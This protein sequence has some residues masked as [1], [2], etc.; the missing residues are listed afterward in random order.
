MK[1]FYVVLCASLVCAMNVFAQATPA[2]DSK[3][4]DCGSSVT[5]TATPL[6]GYHFVQWEDDA[7]APAT[8]TISNIKD[9][10]LKNYKAIFAANQT[11]FG[12]GVDIDV[13]N[14]NVGDPITLTATPTDDCLE[15]T[16]WSDGNT[17]NPR[18][19]TYDGTVPFTAQ[20]QTKVF[21]VTATADDNTQGSVSVTPVVP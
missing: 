6:D 3:N 2:S 14:P 17:D 5:I 21:T 11:D 19:F 18:T 10:T 8:R 20:Y 16:Q 4:V 1:R 9:A 12:D 13:P 15:F 7:T